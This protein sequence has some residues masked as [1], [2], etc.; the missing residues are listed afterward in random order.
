[1][2]PEK[3]PLFENYLSTHLSQIVNP[4]TRQN[5]KQRLIH[6]YFS[7][8]PTAKDASILEIG[9]GFGELIELLANDLSYSKVQGV[10]LSKEVMELCNSIVPNV[11][12]QV[13]NTQDF[14]SK[15]SNTIDTVFMLHVL[16]HVPKNE[17][18][19]LLSAIYDSL[20]PDGVFILEVPN[21]A[22]PITGLNIRYADFTHESGF[23]EVSLKYILQKSGFTDISVYP[24]RVATTSV[25][26]YIQ[27]VLQSVVN[28]IFDLLRRVYMPSQPQIMAPA[29]FAVAKK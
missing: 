22:N 11:V 14:L 19:S 23:T 4:R 16:E 1:M 15:R 18:I 25:P 26:R 24:S 5:K 21:M 13:D 6:N 2:S 9:P 27:S 3:N 28:G 20:A 10:D 12:I 8:L 29:I 7:F 17:A